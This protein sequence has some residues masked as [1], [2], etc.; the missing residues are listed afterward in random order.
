MMDGLVSLQTMFHCPSCGTETRG[1]FCSK[2]GEREVTDED[3]SV[4]RFLKEIGVTITLLESK[5]LR[6]VWIVEQTRIFEY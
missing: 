3:Y 1:Q 6:S 4:R 2:G 5:V